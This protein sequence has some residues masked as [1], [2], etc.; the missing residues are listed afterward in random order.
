MKA[1]VEQWEALAGLGETRPGAIQ[2]PTGAGVGAIGGGASGPGQ[3]GGTVW[4]WLRGRVGVRE[5]RRAPA[6]MLWELARGCQGATGR[7]WEGPGHA[8]WSLIGGLD[9]SWAVVLVP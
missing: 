7:G 5:G 6:R 4:L 9:V 2:A 1:N 8:L 3:Q